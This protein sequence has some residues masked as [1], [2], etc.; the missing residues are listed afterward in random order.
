[1]WFVYICVIFTGTS[2]TSASLK[3]VKVLNSEENV[4][5]DDMRSTPKKSRQKKVK[6]SEVI[7]ADMSSEMIDSNSK[8]QL[9]FFVS[10]ENKI[11]ELESAAESWIEETKSKML[12]KS[13]KMKKAKTDSDEHT[14][15]ET[16]K[17]SSKTKKEK[18]ES[19]EICISET[20]KKSRVKTEKVKSEENDA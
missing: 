20:P 8:A 2:R 16:P 12:K 19:T 6:E 9:K 15:S 3:G 13:S 1:M 7:D 4:E 17:K 5:S 10:Q 11:S 14:K 18:V